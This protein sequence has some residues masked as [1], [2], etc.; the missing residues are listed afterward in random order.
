MRYGGVLF[1]EFSYKFLAIVQSMNPSVLQRVAGGDSTAIRECIDQH[2]ALVWSLARRLSRTP[3]DAEDAT[4]EIFLDI[5]RSAARFDASQGSEKVFIAMIARRR[6]IDRLRKTT[7]EPPMDSVDVLE[8]ATC[9]DP[10]SASETSLE[11][12]HAMRALAEL[13]PEQR[14]VLELGLLHGLS[15]SE[16]ATRLSMPLGTVKSFMRRGLIRVREFMKIDDQ[17]RSERSDD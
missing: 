11:A 3:S 1:S 14:Q 7:A 12:E 10:G 15:Q 2:G 4:Q 5:W 13:R 8:F 17:R 9:S 6:L 16:I